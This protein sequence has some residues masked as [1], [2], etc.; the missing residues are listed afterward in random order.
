LDINLEVIDTTAALYPEKEGSIATPSSSP[1]I[2]I[3]HHNADSFGNLFRLCDRKLLDGV[4]TIGIWVWEVMAF[5]PEWIDAFGAVDEI[6]TPSTFVTD[7]VKAAAPSGIPVRT[8]PYVVEAQNPVPNYRR[9]DFGIPD[10]AFAFLC[11]FDASSTFERKNPTAVLKAF[12][13]TFENDTAAFLV[14]K[15]H[16][17][18]VDAFNIAAMSRKYA[19]SNVLFLDILMP[20]EQLAAL[21]QL[22]DCLISAHRSEGFGLNIAEAMALGKPVIATEYSGNPTFCNETNSLLV[23]AC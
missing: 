5:R 19:A 7:A 13:E 9:S 16:S 15:F 6:W 12:T 4:H 23:R 8:I 20:E 14:M 22:A 1:D 3:L 21:K 2:I 10:E 18:D 17:G 11:V